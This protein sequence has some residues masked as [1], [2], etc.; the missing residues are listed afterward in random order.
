M[1]KTIEKI[2]KTKGNTKILIILSS[3]SV[4]EYE[5]PSKTRQIYS[6]R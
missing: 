4:D 2:N 3:I 6:V 1:F 5:Y